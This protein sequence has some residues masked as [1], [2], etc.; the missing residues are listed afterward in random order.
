MKAVNL[1]NVSQL[2]GFDEI[3]DVRTPA[4]FAQDH[5]P[6]AINCPV[7]SNEERITIGTLYKQVSAFDAKKQGAALVSRN[8]A[9][10][11]ETTFADKPRDWQPLVYCWRGGNRSGALAHVLAQVGWKT[12]QL[13]GG[14]KAY[15]SHVLER[16]ADLPQH[17]SWRIV[18]GP[19]GSG[20]S[21][22]LQILAEEGFQVLDLEQLAAHRGSV[23][24]NL[25]DAPQPAQKMFDSLV[26]AQLQAFDPSRPVYAE[27][28]SK[29]IGALQV[30][31]ALLNAMREGEC[32]RLIADIPARTQLLKEE[33]GHFLQAS[34][35]LNEKLA[36]LTPLHGHERIREW[37]EL[38]S[39]GRWDE[40]VERLLVEHYDPAYG[41]SIFKNFRRFDEAL[42]LTAAALDPATLRRLATALKTAQEAA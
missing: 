38:A 21:R 12:G 29:K 5:I 4:E 3:I 25:P 10:H 33:Y 23:L 22:F 37:Q 14:Y 35:A 2:G 16:L 9:H 8:I 17:F 1:V 42:P 41:R 18:C 27:A 6:G 40:L 32:V 28:E 24:G 36:L 15:R 34:E 31:D 26:L 11:L 39:A 19:T 13:E 7:L 20:K 30:P